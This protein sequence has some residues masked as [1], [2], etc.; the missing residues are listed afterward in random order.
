[1]TRIAC[2]LTLLV[3]SAGCK[4]SKPEA[5]PEKGATAV[6]EHP[7]QGGKHEDIPKVVKLTPEVIREA[8]VRTEP[9]HRRTLAASAE[10]SGQIVPNPEAIAMIG[11]RASGRIIKILVREADHVRAGQVVAILSSPEIAKLRGQ[12]SAAQ[13]RALS[14]RGNA[15]RLRELFQDRLGAEQEAV[16]A[17]AEATAAEAERDAFSRS[18]RGLGA[19]ASGSADSSS[20]PLTTPIAGSVVQLDV[21]IG[22]VVEPSHTVA[23]VADLSRV[24]FEAQVFEKD[25]SRIAQGASAE[26]RLNGYPDRVFTARVARLSGRVDPQARTVTARLV[27]LDPDENLRLGLYGTARV[28]V[29]STDSREHLAVPLSAVTDLGDSKAVFVRHPD[30]DFEVHEVR[31][32]PSVGGFAPVLAGLK[33]GEEVV[34]SGVHTLKS[35]VLKGSM[36]EEE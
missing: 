11:A 15:T 32:G 12:Y 19:T 9:A 14:A 24:W 31:L 17:E 2:L 4:K 36:Q 28:S 6:A 18:L 30:G 35:A 25:L 34:V 33:E 16:S 7:E 23:T 5:A 26:V 20:V 1:M 13:A 3:A 27:L 21:A 8:R 22:Q 29:R 10:L